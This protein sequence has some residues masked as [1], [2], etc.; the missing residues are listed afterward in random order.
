MTPEQLV[1]EIKKMVL[2]APFPIG[3]IVVTGEGD[4]CVSAYSIS[5][6]MPV[7]AV[8]AQLAAVQYKLITSEDI[9][10]Q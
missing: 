2:A 4:K 7:P 6:E 8:V 5:N 3:F 10:S 9:V 1:A